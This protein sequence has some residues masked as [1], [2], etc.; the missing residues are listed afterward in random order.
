MRQI[1]HIVSAIN[2]EHVVAETGTTE[3]RLAQRDPR[4]RLTLLSLTAAAGLAGCSGGG[5]DAARPGSVAP[6]VSSSPA[7]SPSHTA[8][9]R[10]A[11]TT[12]APETSPPATSPAATVARCSAAVLKFANHGYKAGGNETV[13]VTATNV[14][15]QPCE[16]GGYFGV[17]ELNQGGVLIVH[18]RRVSAGLTPQKFSLQPGQSASFKIRDTDV[19]PNGAMGCPTV[20]SFAITAPDTTDTVRVPVT[21]GG[22]M[23]TGLLGCNN[24]EVLPTLFGIQTGM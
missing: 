4:R 10:H 23:T 9:P 13:I 12:R 11:P 20:T 24:A 16:T 5:H 8:T 22:E 21:L 2:G 18:A 7:T 1:R 15:Q 17:D 6:T 14:S 3:I 19:P